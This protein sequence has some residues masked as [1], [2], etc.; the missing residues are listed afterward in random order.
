MVAAQLE[1]IVHDARGK[2]MFVEVASFSS[3][4]EGVRLHADQKAIDLYKDHTTSEQYHAEIK[5]D[6][7]L[8]RLPSGKLATNQLP[9]STG[10]DGP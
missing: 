4:A 3:S 5:T 10:Q 1:A 2:Q 8:E 6:M 9:Q 7:Y